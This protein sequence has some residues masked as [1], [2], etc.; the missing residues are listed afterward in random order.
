VA[1]YN[2]DPSQALE[3]AFRATTV[4]L[5][6]RDASDAA[7]LLAEWSELGG[8]GP[9]NGA[10]RQAMEAGL[11]A[12]DGRTKEALALYREAL[13]GW[14]ATNSVWD[15]AMTGL[16]MATLLN[17]GEPEVAAAVAS[18]R[19]IY[20]HLGAKPY[21]EW[22]DELSATRTPTPVARPAMET[23]VAQAAVTE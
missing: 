3:Y 14:R 4:A 7:Q 17:V 13:A 10:R 5:L 23:S 9:V 15:E 12:L 22:L 11:A 20:E 2:T 18:A 21:M 6:A 8:Y 16:Q 19:A 1:V